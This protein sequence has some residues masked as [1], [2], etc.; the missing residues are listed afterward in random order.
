MRGYLVGVDPVI[1]AVLYSL[2]QIREDVHR[3]TDGLTDEQLWYAEGG[4]ASAGFHLRHL[5]GSIDRLTTYADGKT[6]TGEQLA[7]L[8]AEKQR[9]LTRPQLLT[10]LETAIVKA[11]AML[12]TTTPAE[13]GAHREIG[14]L[15]IPTTLV[16]LLIH[17][18]EHGQRHLGAMISAIRLATLQRSV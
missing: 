7:A 14:R 1:A 8:D 6:L 17:T 10:M 11:E 4:L 9:D 5:A 12:R 13:F 15:R 16:G 18:A 2:Q 3:W